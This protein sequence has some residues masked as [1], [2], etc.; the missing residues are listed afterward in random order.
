M[1]IA[2]TFSCSKIAIDL[3]METLIFLIRQFVLSND[4]RKYLGINSFNIQILPKCFFA[5]I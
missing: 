5:M 1:I 2:N 3:L 4:F